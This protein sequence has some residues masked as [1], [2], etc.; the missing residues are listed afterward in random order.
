MAPHPMHS[1]LHRAVT[2]C[3]P[4]SGRCERTFRNSAYAIGLALSNTPR[5]GVLPV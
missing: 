2:R 1:A 4:I 3:K 5:L